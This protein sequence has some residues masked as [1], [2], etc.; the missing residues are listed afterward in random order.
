MK[1]SAKEA[2]KSK[3]PKIHAEKTCWKLVAKKGCEKKKE[4]KSFFFFAKFVQKRSCDCERN[5][6]KSGQ[7]SREKK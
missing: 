4:N 7:K 5:R 2:K 3:T 6:L 1:S